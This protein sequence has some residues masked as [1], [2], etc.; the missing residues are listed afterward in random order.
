MRPEWDLVEPCEATLESWGGQT[1]TIT[2][3]HYPDWAAFT[4]EFLCMSDQRIVQ[5]DEGGV[6]LRADNGEAQ[7]VYRDVRT[8]DSGVL[9][10]AEKV[11]GG[12]GEFLPHPLSHP[13]SPAE[14]AGFR[15]LLGPV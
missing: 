6:V 11:A 3:D 4:S 10:L 12:V 14:V 5:P 15:P 1:T 7:Y 13:L 8:S 2:I 9:F